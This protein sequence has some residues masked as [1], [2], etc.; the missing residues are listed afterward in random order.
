MDSSKI[1]S[2]QDLKYGMF[3]HFGLFSLCGGVWNG[4]EIRKGYAEQI[5]SQADIPQADY[6]ALIDD[7]DIPNFDADKIA[8]LA[9]DAGMKYIVLVTKHHDGFCLFDTKTTIY[10]S[11]NS[12]CHR[13]LVDEMSKACKKAGLKFGVY[14]SWIDWHCP[15]A[16]PISD[17]NSDR[18]PEKHMMLNIHQ[19]TELLSNYGDICELWMDMGYPTKEQ[20]LTIRNLAHSLQPNI[21]LNGRVWNDC[22]DFI[23]MGDNEYPKVKLDL[24]WQTPATIYHETWGYRSY[25]KRLN[26][27]KKIKEITSSL[28]SVLNGG[29]NYLLNIGPDDTGAIVPFEAEVLRGVGKNIQKE[30]LIRNPLSLKIKPLCLKDEVKLMNGDIKFRYTGSEYYTFHA[31]ATT[32]EWYV[33]VEEE[34]LYSIDWK[35]PSKLIH[36][37]K[38]CIECGEKI[39]NFTLKKDYEKA[40]IISSI[41]LKKGL[42]KIN[43]H[44]CGDPLC[45]PELKQPWIE[46]GLKKN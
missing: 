7:F 35:L 38:L 27:D 24:P 8:Q 18:I 46:L 10:N 3:I 30:G 20:S 32:V 29:G 9:V 17:H 11:S 26:S 16:L 43:L 40:I 44:S 25:Q 39:I 12:A 21:M 15:D 31:I 2:W 14:F 4:K 41:K 34:G 33:N 45:R 1:Q 36:E 19:I 13:D 37:I 42:I 5:I 28:Y 23:T 22:G 6:E